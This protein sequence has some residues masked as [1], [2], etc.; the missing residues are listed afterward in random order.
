MSSRNKLFYVKIFP[1]LKGFGVLSLALL[2]FTQIWA[3]N[4]IRL[5]V[6]KVESFQSKYFSIN[7]ISISISF[8]STDEIAINLH[9]E[10]ISSEYISDIKSITA[11][12]NSIKL[13][14]Q[15]YDCTDGKLIIEHPLFDDAGS[16]ITFSYH[17]TQ[18]LKSFSITKLIFSQGQ[19]TVDA[20]KKGKNWSVT[21]NSQNIDLP[22][23]FNLVETSNET[24]SNYPVENGTMNLN[25]SIHF[26]QSR[27]QSAQVETSF[28]NLSMD[29]EQVMEN[30][31]LKTKLELI[32]KQQTWVFSNTTQFLSGALYLV[33]GFDVF[34]EKPG[35]YLDINDQPLNMN[36]SGKSDLEFTSY[37]INQFEYQQGD[38]IEVNGLGKIDLTADQ[39]IESLSLQ[40]NAPNLKDIYPIYIQPILLPTNYSDLELSGGI[41]VNIDH[42]HNQ[43]QSLQLEFDDIYIDDQFNRF[44]I[45]GLNSEI[46]LEESNRTQSSSVSW[47]GMSVYKILFG[48]GDMDFSSLGKNF[49]VQKW[50]DVNLLDGG[51]SINKLSL[52]NLGQED[53]KLVLDG[54]LKPISLSIFTQV[55]GWPLM[56]GTLA[57]EISGFQYSNNNLILDGDIKFKVF[58]GDIILSDFSIENL[59]SNYSRL[60]THIDLTNLDLQQLSKTFTFGEIKGTLNGKMHEFTLENWQPVYFDAAFSTPEDDA[61]P[62]RISQKALDNLSELGGGI[63]GVLSNSLL[64]FIP[65]YSYG[66][67]GFSCRLSNGICNLG[68]VKETEHGFYILT[69]GGLFPPW[70][71]VMGT[72]RSIKWDHLIDG[73]KQIAEGEVAIE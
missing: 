21:I 49:Q 18:G 68:G 72:G 53:F 39:I 5:S 17:L 19:H 36:I 31:T 12:C 62:H 44:S 54:E 51:L 4:D 57:G 14:N 33:P 7:D 61:R 73:L 8:K 32:Q 43:L 42:Q 38:L 25:A 13:S 10:D 63:T 66:Q 60:R 47:D 23:L 67:L 48:A 3:M 71:D 16:P 30:V 11:Q 69:K 22:T 20:Q 29:A 50:Q 64:K 58:D 26:D 6:N 27:V 40:V 52:N 56:S 9:T 2:L 35:F 37:E 1:V 28:E 70:V 45:S 41:R 46:N 24:L 55:M 34:K 15:T 65:E 59:F